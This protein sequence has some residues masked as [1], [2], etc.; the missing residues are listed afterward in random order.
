MSSQSAVWQTAQSGVRL[1]NCHI[2]SVVQ[3]LSCL[4]YIDTNLTF[5]T[6]FGLDRVEFTTLSKKPPT[7]GNTVRVVRIFLALFEIVEALD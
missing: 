7:S 1:G 2:I 5:D 3:N 6:L 4:S